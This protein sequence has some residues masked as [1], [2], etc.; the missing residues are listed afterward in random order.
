[1]TIA[2]VRMQVHH[3]GDEREPVVVIDAATGHAAAL[4]EH[5]ATRSAF[6]PAAH[7]GS[8]YPGLLGP[9]PTGYV[10]GLVRRMLPLIA[11][12]FGTGVVRPVRARG[13]FSLVTT[14]PAALDVD[15]C[16]PHVD[17]ADRMQ[18]AC[19]HYLCGPDH[20]GTAFFRHRATGYET[21]DPARLP[22][23]AAAREGDP[24]AWGYPGEDAA[25][26]VTATCRAV[27]DRIVLYRAALLHSGAIAAP[28]PHAADP[29]R[30][31]LTGNLFVQCAGVAA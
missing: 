31:R 17:A 14:D 16:A 9:A 4:V 27:P 24:V 11:A 6:A 10:D 15:Q 30:G 2:A 22:A 8:G 18:F 25:F 19:V 20:G 29:R 28:P 1:M 7:V 23:Y 5:A 21:I 3:V 26:A 12:H 13:N